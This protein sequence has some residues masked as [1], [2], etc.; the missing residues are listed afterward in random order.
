MRWHIKKKSYTHYK[1]R[2]N[3]RTWVSHPLLCLSF[4]VCNS[5]KLLLLISVLIT[6]KA[7]LIWCSC[8]TCYFMG[9]QGL[10]K[11]LQLLPWP[12]NCMGMPH[13]LS[14]SPA[15]IMYYELQNAITK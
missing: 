3:H 11:P 1:K 15:H 8:H 6:I 7:F 10:A 2:L 13:C 9:H 12:G 14:T 4:R 5:A